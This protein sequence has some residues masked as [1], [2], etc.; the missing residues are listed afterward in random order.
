MQELDLKTPYTFVANVHLGLYVGPLRSG[1]QAISVS[2]SSQ[3]DPL[4][5]YLDAWLGLSGRGCA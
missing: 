1:A 3:L 4:P 2:V 5:H